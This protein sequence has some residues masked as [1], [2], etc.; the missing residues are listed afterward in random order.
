MSMLHTRAN[1][2]VQKFKRIRALIELLGRLFL[3]CSCRDDG[4][5][6]LSERIR[7]QGSFATRC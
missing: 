1:F 2:G 4:I 5:T 6:G 3:T 7:L